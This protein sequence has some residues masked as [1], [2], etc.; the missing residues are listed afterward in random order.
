MQIV[1]DFIRDVDNHILDDIIEDIDLSNYKIN[2][3]F[4]EVLKEDYLYYM[5]YYGH[6]EDEDK[7]IDALSSNKVVELFIKHR[8]ELLSEVE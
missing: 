5:G 4:A 1:K 8:A 3:E 2:D 7:E 6:N